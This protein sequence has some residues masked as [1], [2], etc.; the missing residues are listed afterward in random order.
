MKPALRKMLRRVIGPAAALVVIGAGFPALAGP[1]AGAGPVEGPAPTAGIEQPG[2]PVAVPVESP[3]EFAW[4]TPTTQDRIGRLLAPVYVNGQGPFRFIIDTGASSSAVAP[5]LAAALGLQADEGA[6][7]SLRGVTGTQRV[8]SIRV[9]EMR[10]GELRLRNRRLPVVEEGVF[11]DA[12]GILGVEGFEDAC[13]VALFRESRVVILRN[14]CPISRLGW[15]KVEARMA[16]G[17]LMMVPAT[18]AGVKVKAIVDTG[19]ERS[20]GNPALLEALELERGAEDPSRATQVLGATSHVVEASLVP[21]P[22]IYLGDVNVA[23]LHVTFGDF[24]VF[25][26][27]GLEAEPAILLGMDV[28]GTVD[29]L[30]IDYRREELRFRPAGSD[31]MNKIGINRRPPFGRLP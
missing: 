30:M 18:I 21:S 23:D 6:M 27:W 12:D 5:G 31:E 20:L 14:G 11:A 29:A 10:A 13:L 7:V 3:S 16:F 1:E 19:A 25:A 9:D 4:V 2:P 15:P 24:A 22:R 8:P 26:L 17:R 28:L